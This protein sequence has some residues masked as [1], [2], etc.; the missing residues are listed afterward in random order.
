MVFKKA[1]LMFRPKNP[2]LVEVRGT[3][4]ANEMVELMVDNWDQLQD[5]FNDY[6]EAEKDEMMD[7]FNCCINNLGDS[8]FGDEANPE[9]F[10]QFIDGLEDEQEV[11]FLESVREALLIDYE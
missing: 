5:K 7:H 11:D 1:K 9:D 6:S 8:L 2:G 4:K 10:K 3:E